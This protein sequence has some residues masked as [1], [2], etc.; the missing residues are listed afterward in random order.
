MHPTFIY[1]H[2]P[3]RI[4]NRSSRRT[5]QKRWF[6]FVFFF[7]ILF[8]AITLL[9]SLTETTN[10]IL[11]SPW[12]P[13]RLFFNFPNRRIFYL[14]WYLSAGWWAHRVFVIF[15]GYL[16]KRFCCVR[17]GLVVYHIVSNVFHFRVGVIPKELKYHTYDVIYW[18]VE[19][20][21]FYCTYFLNYWL[22]KIYI[23]FPATNKITSFLCSIILFLI[24]RHQRR[25]FFRW[26]ICAGNS[27]FNFIKIQY[28]E[29]T[30]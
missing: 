26:F 18:G 19:S 25:F 6:L 2:E 12:R 17:F 21:I 30:S 13:L 22:N 5:S 27:Q 9:R 11:A 7:F 4:R 1:F 24:Y 20:Y 29:I 16:F 8:R 14:L 28:F 23:I 10:S 15:S 3:V